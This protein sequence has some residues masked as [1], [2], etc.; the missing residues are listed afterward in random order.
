MLKPLSMTAVCSV[1]LQSMFPFHSVVL[2]LVDVDGLNSQ[3]AEDAHI[4]PLSIQLVL[5]CVD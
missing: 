3:S 1:P 4:F 2:L 5:E